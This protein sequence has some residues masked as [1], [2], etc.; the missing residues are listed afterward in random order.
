MT[1]TSGIVASVENRSPAAN[2]GISLSMV[3]LSD[4]SPAA[5]AAALAFG[6]SVKLYSLCMGAPVVVAGGCVRAPLCG[7]GMGR[8]PVFLLGGFD[9]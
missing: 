1:N 8:P 5:L 3:K 6:V 4:E 7:V 2:R 9:A